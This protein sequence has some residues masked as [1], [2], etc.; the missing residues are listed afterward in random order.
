MKIKFFD[1]LPST[2]KYCELLNLNEVEE[3]TCYC[4]HT[5]TAG[6]GQGDHL[7]HSA[8]GQNLTFSLV[9][10]P[11]FLPARLQF[12]L[13]QALSLGITDWL[14]SQLST[15]HS[16]LSI[17]HPND[18]Y[19]GHS[20]LCGTLITTRLQGQRIL[21]AVA[22]IGLNLNQTEFPPELPNP[23]SLKQITGRDYPLQAS[24]ESLLA[25][26]RA[27]YEAL[28]LDPDAP[29]SDYQKLLYNPTPTTE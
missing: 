29:L 6:I 25:S 27:R 26:L 1:S 7:W 19:L 8:P 20:K 15:P 21:H 2:N 28:R 17:K 23:I 4:A 10:H 5:Q 11:T 12:R 24:L 18:I 14:H 3:F 13:T 16:P 9:L 22:G